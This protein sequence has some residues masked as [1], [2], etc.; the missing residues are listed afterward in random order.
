MADAQHLLYNRAA[1]YD[2]E[3][4]I[5]HTISHQRRVDAGRPE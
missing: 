1:D 4:K 2:Y 5:L 3:A